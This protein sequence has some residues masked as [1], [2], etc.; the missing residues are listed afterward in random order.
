MALTDLIRQARPH[1]W[2]KN[3][4]VLFPAVFASKMAD[5]AVWGK[6]LLTAAGFSLVASA[7]YILNDI[8]DREQDREHPSKRNR[9]LA[10]GKV[11][12]A[13]A[14]IE[15]ALLLAAG[16]ALVAPLGPG[17]LLLVVVYLA[18][19]TAYTLALKQRILIDVICIALGFVL[20]AVAGAMAIH[21]LVSPWLF[22]C[23]WL[24]LCAWLFLRAW[25]L[26][27]RALLILRVFLILL[28]LL[29]RLFLILLRA[30]LILL[31]LLL[32]LFLIL[33]RALLILLLLLLH[34]FLILL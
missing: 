33:L 23:T 15:A 31:L 25:L 20:R 27:P 29:L 22:L 7:V 3:V 4:V 17:V 8:R 2:I 9:P 21:V 13:A 18:L 32:R 24:L 5:P 10:A 34:A 28:L 12:L 1:H 16:L 14:V 30:F 19:Q 6:V 11:S 26:R